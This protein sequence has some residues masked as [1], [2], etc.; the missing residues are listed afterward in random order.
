[1]G[2]RHHGKCRVQ[3][4]ERHCYLDSML[5]SNSSSLSARWH[6]YNTEQ[7]I[8]WIRTLSFVKARE[9]VVDDD[10][11]NALLYLLKLFVRKLWCWF[12]LIPWENPFEVDPEQVVQGNHDAKQFAHKDATSIVA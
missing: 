4:R 9:A 12:D 5:G 7:R 3:Q 11:E 1:M 2:E 10:K 8:R 6:I